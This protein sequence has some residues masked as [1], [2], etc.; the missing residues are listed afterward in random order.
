MNIQAVSSLLPYFTLGLFIVGLFLT[1]SRIILADLEL[2]QLDIPHE[3][4][5]IATAAAAGR[6]AAGVPVGAAQNRYGARPSAR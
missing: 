5:A 3:Y 2:H 6:A 4:A 1:R